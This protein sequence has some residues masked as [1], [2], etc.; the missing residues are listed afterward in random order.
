MAELAERARVQAWAEVGAA[1]ESRLIDTLPIPPDPS[2]EADK[3]AR[4]RAFLDINLRALEK[5]AKRRG[6]R[7]A[8]H[9]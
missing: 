7:K 2:Y 9:G 6:H 4:I 8:G 1:I 5:Q 3:D